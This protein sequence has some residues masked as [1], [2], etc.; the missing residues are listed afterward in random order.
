MRPH[1]KVFGGLNSLFESQQFSW[2]ENVANNALWLP[3]FTPVRSDYLRF[4]S[5]LLKTFCSLDICCA[6]VETYPSYIAG[7]L[8]TYYVDTLRISQLCI[9]R[10]DSPILDKLYGTF[11]TFEVGPFGFRMSEA[12]EYSSLPDYSPYVITY[13]GVTLP[14]LISIVDASLR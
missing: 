11:P 14:F 5:H 10:T 2:R 12:D 13:E 7:V 4:V 1:G 8:S 6:C 9:A 3:L